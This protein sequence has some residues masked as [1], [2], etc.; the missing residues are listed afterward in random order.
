MKICMIVLSTVK[1]DIRVEKEIRT[2][3]ENGHEIEV[4]GAA[5]PDK[6][7]IPLSEVVQ[8]KEEKKYK[9]DR[10]EIR[11]GGIFKY[12]EFWKGVKQIFK[13]EN[14]KYNVIHYHDLN[15]LPLVK[16]FKK[17]AKYHI[18]DSHE[19]FP[20]M[21]SETYGRVG[22]I[23]FNWLERI[24]IKQVHHVITTVE[25]IGDEMLKKYP[26]IKIS[27]IHN[28]PSVID[29]NI[30]N[31]RKPKFKADSTKLSVVAWGTVYPN[32]GYDILVDVVKDISQT[33]K[34][35]DIEFIIIGS[36]QELEPMKRR[37]SENNL[38]GYF[39]FLGW[40]NYYDAL[41]IM[42]ETDLGLC[43]LQPAYS[44]HKEFC[45]PNR[46]FDYLATGNLIICSDVDSIKNQFPKNNNFSFFV[47]PRDVEEI[48]EKILDVFEIHK[49]D[50]LEKVKKQSY[51]TFVKI[52]NWDKE[53]EI[54]LKIYDSFNTKEF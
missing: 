36:G 3:L 17:K 47:K 6:E 39:F 5:F 48:K 35:S 8:V 31:E 43:L 14:R 7:E 11:K 25:G 23:A 12:L 49:K 41:A 26:G 45:S 28:Y 1:P 38:E 18:Y 52:L 53:G 54:L 20:E 37:V 29:I 40:T 4:I 44:K 50:S 21:M 42:K 9:I 46:V 51:E 2:L 15:V 13:K 10:I 22:L 33:V 32:Y 34:S 27:F 24:Y 19:L 16:K 30:S